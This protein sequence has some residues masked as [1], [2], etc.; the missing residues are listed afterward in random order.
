MSFDKGFC[1]LE[2]GGVHDTRCVYTVVHE[3]ILSVFEVNLMSVPVSVGGFFTIDSLLL[4]I[5]EA[6][7]HL[8]GLV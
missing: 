4:S 1:D 7:M 2:T 8:W 6:L 5:A 3:E